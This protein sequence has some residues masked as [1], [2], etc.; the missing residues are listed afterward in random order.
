MIAR[1]AAQQDQTAIRTQHYI[2]RK[3]NRLIQSRAKITGTAIIRTLFTCS[4]LTSDS[5]DNINPACCLCWLISCLS[6]MW[7]LKCLC[8]HDNREPAGGKSRRVCNA[9]GAA[10]AS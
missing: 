1:E 3:H 5:D 8:N 2:L 7:C 9:L 6:E 4:P 10:R